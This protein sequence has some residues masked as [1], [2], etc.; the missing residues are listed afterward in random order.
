MPPPPVPPAV[1]PSPRA[2]APAPTAGGVPPRGNARRAARLP[3]T[4][5]PRRSNS[6]DAGACSCWRWWPA[7]SCWRWARWSPSWWRCSR[8]RRPPAGRQPPHR[9]PR[10]GH[11]GPHHRHL[12][13]HDRRHRPVRHAPAL[14]PHVCDGGR[15]LRLRG[16]AQRRR[17]RH[18]D[19]PNLPRRLPMERVN[20][21]RHGRDGHPRGGAIGRCASP[22]RSVDIRH[23]DG[24]I[25]TYQ[26]YAQQVV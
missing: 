2:R 7:A 25:E 15:A 12:R 14:A 11:P 26:T 17:D 8:R 9:A 19:L 20:L 1:R 24:I 6:P 3:W 22:H 23:S 16:G 21:Q 4:R 13:Q 10:V 18:P 5:P